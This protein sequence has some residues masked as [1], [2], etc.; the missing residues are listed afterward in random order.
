M[1]S[2]RF[3]FMAQMSFTWGEINFHPEISG[4]APGTP[5]PTIYKWLAFSIGC[6]PTRW[7][8]QILYFLFSPRNLGKM[9][10]FWLINIFQM[11]WFNGPC[12][13]IFTYR[14]W[15]VQS[16]NIHPWQKL[17]GFRVQ[18]VGPPAVSRWIRRGGIWFVEPGKNPKTFLDWL[19]DR[20]VWSL[21]KFPCVFFFG[22]MWEIFM[23]VYLVAYTYDSG[24]RGWNLNFV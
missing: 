12:L 7:W 17:V 18:L 8:F 19:Q 16:P 13:P 11:G 15:L 24:S 9:N 20:I 21:V 14:K 3:F 22:K 6:F 23:Y 5:R 1:E 4:V 10:P 2:R